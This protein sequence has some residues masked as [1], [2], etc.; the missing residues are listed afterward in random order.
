MR[1]AGGRNVAKRRKMDFASRSDRI[2]FPRTGYAKSAAIDYYRSISPILLPHLRNRPVAFR[3][4]PGSIADESFCEKDAPSFTPDWIKTVAVPRKRDNS[5]IRYIVIKDERSLLW[6]AE[7]GV[8][9]LHPFLHT[10][11]NLQQPSSVVF[12]L[13]PGPRATMAHCCRVAVRLRDYLREI[14]LHSVVKVSGSKG[15]QVYVPLNTA[16]TYAATEAFAR[17]VAHALARAH[18]RLIVADMARELRVG[19]VFIDWSQN[20]DYKTTV[21]VYSLR[22]MSDRPWVS[23]PVTWNEV[24]DEQHNR[25][26]TRLRFAPEEALARAA[27]LGDL[28][29][30][31]LKIKQQ[32][33]KQ[34]MRAL[35]RA[36]PKRRLSRPSDDGDEEAGAEVRGIRL[37]R[38]RSQSGRRLF[39]LIESEMGNEL[40]LDV[41]GQFQRFILRPDRAGGSRVIAMPAGE[42]PVDEAY[43]RGEVQEEYRD[44]IRIGDLGF[45][46]IIDGSFHAERLELHFNGA[47]MQGPWV[48]EKIQKRSRHRSWSLTLAQQG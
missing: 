7:V 32:L 10:A 3:R 16:V 15:L 23:M 18:P 14:S 31:L 44:R 9:E 42:F 12:D 29:A 45:Y 33:P 43:Y 27:H 39:V 38:P 35:T 1:L 5:V 6:A 25:S 30:P 48:L 11:R 17:V 40:W 41:R 47:K 13:D 24:E 36:S 37:P 22:A 21:A 20:S 8:V 26:K 2:L 4:F 46:E 19:R 28:F 34:F